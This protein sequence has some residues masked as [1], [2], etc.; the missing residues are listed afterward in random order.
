MTDQV[1]IYSGDTVKVVSLDKNKGLSLGEGPSNQVQFPPNSCPD[2]SVRFYFQRG[3]WNVACT[4]EVYCSGKPASSGRVVSGEMFVLNRR[5]HLA[6]QFIQRQDTAPV[7]V[8]LEGLE[9]LLIG[10]SA[11]CALQLS[12]NKVSGGHA[13][14]YLDGTGWRICDINSTNGTFVSG[15][16]VQDQLLRDG[17]VI[18]IGPYDLVYSG[19]M[20]QVYGEA[21]SIVSHRLE[22]RARPAEKR[23]HHTE[24]RR[25]PPKPYPYFT[26]SPRL[27][28]E[29][30]RI[31][32]EIEAAPSI[33]GAPEI[34]WVSVLMPVMG[35][36][37]ASLVLTLFT[38][39]FG[40]L[41]SIPTPSYFV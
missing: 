40:M 24:E 12:H 20:L 1:R 35:T 16:R 36:L 23:T 19:G 26:R 2:S 32:V 7:T 8:S 18:F 28:R 33:G 15:K 5:S 14:L 30:P 4:G 27:L 38:G 34:N 37:V 13:K 17:D 3:G 22:Q 31:T 10:R 11:S 25:D 6:V 29:Q 41:F 21:S 9:E 39:G